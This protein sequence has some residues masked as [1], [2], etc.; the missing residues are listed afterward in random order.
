[1]KEHRP[2]M[3]QS[4]D[5]WEYRTRC[6][7]GWKSGWNWLNDVHADLT[8]HIFANRPLTKAGL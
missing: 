8:R 4:K 3:I 6:S 2:L 7:C 1:M 5:K